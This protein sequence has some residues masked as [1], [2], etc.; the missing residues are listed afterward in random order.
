MATPLTRV[1]HRSSEADL[2]AMW[3]EQ[4]NAWHLGFA[5]VW[6][7]TFVV[8][9]LAPAGHLG[10]LP[11]MALLV[12]LAVV[13]AA[14]GI[15]GMR[16]GGERRAYT[17]LVLAWLCV[18]GM[19]VLNADTQSWLLYFILF[20]HLWVVLH[21]RLAI[22]TTVLI[23]AALAVMR[24]AQSD[25]SREVLTSIG[26]SSVISL[27]LSL[28]LG[29]FID[30]ILREAQTR[31]RT[32]DELNATRNE[33]SAAERDRGVLEERERLSREIHDTLAQG[34]TSVLALSRAADAALARGDVDTARERLA[35]V[36]ATARDNLSEARLIV[37]E[38][39]PGHLQSRTL[40]EALGRLVS[41]LNAESHVASELTVEGEPVPL[42]GAAEVVLLRTAQEALANVRRHSGADHCSVTLDYQEPTSVVLTVRDDGRGFDKEE[43]RNG[44]G[45]DGLGARAAEVGG[46]LRLTSAPGDGTRVMVEV[47][48]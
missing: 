34:F 18:L 6:A 28:A 41:A 35:L 31:A 25:G 33:L 4:E 13:Y 32:I 9:V 48:R 7:S 16:A 24:I 26:L 30:R 20:P 15:P 47:P 42:G 27:G 11:E 19:Q 23:L 14:F 45:L 10:R 3:A 2:D 17:Y 1:E 36:D 46:S 43:L 38:L 5:L 37:A 21:T 44:F 39:S 8:V 12:V 40:V 22:I 29:L